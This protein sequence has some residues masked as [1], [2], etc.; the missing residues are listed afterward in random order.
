MCRR[1]QIQRSVRP[2]PVA[3]LAT[4]SLLLCLAGCT[5]EAWYEGFK[6]SAESRCQNQP[7]GE[8]QKCLEELNRKS[9]SDYQMERD[10]ARGTP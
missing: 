6:H 5:T 9:Y 7:P 1:I 4:A 2:G 3:R 10:K 8:R